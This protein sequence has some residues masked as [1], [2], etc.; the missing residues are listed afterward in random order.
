MCILRYFSIGYRENNCLQIYIIYEIN[1]VCH[2]Q[3]CQIITDHFGNL[4]QIY[5]LVLP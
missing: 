4:S 2:I 1:R 3:H 5:M